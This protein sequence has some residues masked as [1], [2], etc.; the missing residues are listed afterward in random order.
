MRPSR[1]RSQRRAAPPARNG[2]A[3]GWLV[4]AALTALTGCD[5]DAVI[6]IT[7]ELPADI[8]LY[9]TFELAIRGRP[10][11]DNPFTRFASAQFTLDDETIDVE[12]FYDGDDTWRVRFSPERPGE[13]HYKW[14]LGGQ[15]GSGVLRVGKEP[16]V[17]RPHGDEGRA[18]RHRGH[19]HAVG[20]VRGSLV[21]GDGSPHFWVGAKW[22]S[23]KNYGPTKKDGES[24]DHAEAGSL[25][26][27]HYSD[28]TFYAFL[29]RIADLGFNG[30]LLKLGLF[31][32]EDDGVSWDLEWI[33]RADRWVSAMNERGVYCQLTLFEPWS[34]RLG[35]SFSYSLESSEHV[36]DAWSP[37]RLEDKENY[38]RYAVARFSGYANVYW[39]LA[40]RARHP[41]FDDRRFVEL[42]NEHYG[43]WLAKYDPYKTAVALSDADHARAVEEVTVEVPRTDTHL[44]AP[45]DARKA[46][47]VNELVHD[48]G[49]LGTGARA[50]LNAT[51]RD[52]Q[53][54]TCYRSAGWIAFTSGSFGTAA[55]S[56]L[57]LTEPFT[58]AVDDVFGDLAWLKA[59]V[60]GLPVPFDRLMPDP[61]FVVAGKGHVGTRSRPGQLYVSYFSGPS[62]PDQVELQLT[63]GR[64]T[65]RWFDPATGELL[66]ESTHPLLR[67]GGLVTV[68]RPPIDEDVVL[69]VHNEYAVV[70]R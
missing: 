52:P 42:A 58:P 30:L 14:R 24:N 6:G 29:D 9:Q 40:N 62:G 27:A 67:G 39:E 56:W 55:A 45:A 47:V 68:E 34:R 20:E 13:W 48:C 19:V 53:Y 17:A 38:V 70:V 64:H 65:A 4:G 12:G 66:G 63:M 35:S 36:L 25:H 41:G 43:P 22:L 5:P 18:F 60:T 44:P 51:I 23:A 37:D 57:D 32:L 33:R 16:W 3:W 31:P 46:R 69:L 61:L 50:Y 21:H 15:S 1:E 7:T 28:E 59:F 26:D 10:G 2:S 54:R 8:A 11:P 49:P